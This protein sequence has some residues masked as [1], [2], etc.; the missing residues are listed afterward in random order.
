MKKVAKKSAFSKKVNPKTKK[1]TRNLKVY[2]VKHP[3]ELIV[4]VDHGELLLY[5]FESS[6]P[7]EQKLI[8]EGEYQCWDAA[9]LVT[10]TEWIFE[11][12]EGPGGGRHVEIKIIVPKNLI[13]KIN[14][15]TY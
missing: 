15:E 1:S 13:T 10:E 5:G 8:T 6:D 4:G 12:S 3:I 11:G 7:E 14:F 9:A 2:T